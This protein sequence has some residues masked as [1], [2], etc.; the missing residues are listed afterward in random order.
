MFEG[1]GGAVARMHGVLFAYDAL[2]EGG[3]AEQRVLAFD[4]PPREGDTVLVIDE[5]GPRLAR[6]AERTAPRR[7]VWL[8][9]VVRRPGDYDGHR[10]G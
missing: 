9:G 5:H 6:F 3:P 10:S 7:R 8:V 1:G 2:A 4:Q